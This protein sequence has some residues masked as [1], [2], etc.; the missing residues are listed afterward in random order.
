M[1]FKMKGAPYCKETLNVPVYHMEMEDNTNGMATKN[2][3]T[4]NIGG[5]ENA[6]GI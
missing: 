5:S 1:A 2:G 3:S 4:L 6:S